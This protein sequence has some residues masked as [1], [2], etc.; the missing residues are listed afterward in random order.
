MRNEPSV[1]GYDVLC[2]SDADE[3]LSASSGVALVVQAV[4]HRITTD[5]VLGPG[6]DGWGFDCR[7]LL[8][9]PQHQIQALLPMLSEVAGRD[10]RVLNSVSVAAEFTAN[11]DS[12]FSTVLTFTGETTL[13]PFRLVV[14]VTS[15]GSTWT[16]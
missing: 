9:M 15:L 12:T 1:Y 16:L 2:M 10:E 7:R 4:F 14:D 11:G 6:G 8:G 13:G 3:L 5:D